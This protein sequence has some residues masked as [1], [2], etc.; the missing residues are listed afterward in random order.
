MQIIPAIDILSGKTVRLTNG[1]YDRVTVYESDPVDM[2]KRYL[3][4]G[5]DRIHAVDLDGARSSSPINLR[6]LEKIASIN[7]ALIEWSGGLKSDDAVHDA[8]NAGAT[9]ICGGSIAVLNPAKFENWIKEFG[10]EKIILGAD[11]R[12]GFIAI[13]GWKQETAQTV[14]GLIDTFVPVGLKQVIV[15][16]ISRDGTL[17]GINCKLYEKLQVEYPEIDFTVSGGISSAKDIEEAAAYG[18]RRVIVGKAIYENKISLS[19]L[20]SLNNKE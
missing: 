18:L 14:E 16:D 12:N 10:S 8:F 1:E 5:F 7:G 9:Y 4:H 15:T 2:V 13:Q 19:E 17:E 6:V 20:E 11:I 3:D